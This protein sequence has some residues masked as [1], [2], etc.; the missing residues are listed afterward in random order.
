MSECGGSDLCTGFFQK[1]D[2]LLAAYRRKVIEENGNGVTRRKTVGKIFDRHTR[3]RKNRRSVKD[4]RI[5]YDQSGFHDSETWLHQRSGATSA[6]PFLIQPRTIP[7]PMHAACSQPFAYPVS[8]AHKT[9]IDVQGLTVTMHNPV[10]NY[11]EF[12][13]IR[14]QAGLN[15][16]HC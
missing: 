4:L 13:S 7:C 11:G 6:W 10:F 16:D 2:D 5:G 15:V 3:A 8:K 14:S 12:A 1:R 9:T